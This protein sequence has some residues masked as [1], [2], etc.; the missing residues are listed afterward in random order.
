MT[1][2]FRRHLF[3]RNRRNVIDT[4]VRCS[5]NKPR[6]HKTCY[7]KTLYLVQCHSENASL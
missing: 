2:P 1:N 5:N 7:K 4:A 6:I 3:I